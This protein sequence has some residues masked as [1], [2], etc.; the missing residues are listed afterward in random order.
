V[1]LVI[2]VGLLIVSLTWSVRQIARLHRFGS[3]RDFMPSSTKAFSLMRRSFVSIW[4]VFGTTLALVF[5]W[6]T[7]PSI[8]CLM[9]G[10]AAAYGLEA[11]TKSSGLL[12]FIQAGEEAMAARHARIRA[13]CAPPNLF[14]VQS[15]GKE[16]AP[17]I[18]PVRR[19]WNA[20]LELRSAGARSTAS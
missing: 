18:V 10:I 16:A 14:L 1:R 19:D 6:K 7:L 17:K 2:L 15:G 5:G 8:L 13:E 9:S 11:L 3:G 20:L 4:F 12:S